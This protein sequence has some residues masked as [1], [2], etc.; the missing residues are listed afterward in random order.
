M[1]KD[2]SV[3]N[4]T[5]QGRAH[6]ER[7][8]LVCG[9]PNCGKSHLLRHMLEDKRLGGS[10]HTGNGSVPMRA[11]SRERCLAVRLSSPHESKFDPS[12]YHKSIDKKALAARRQNFR[13]INFAGAIQPGPR[14]LMPGIVEVCSGLIKSFEPE[15][16]RVVQLSPNQYGN[17]DYTLKTDEIDK[18]RRL[19]VEF[20]SIDARRGGGTVESANVRIL[21]DFFDFS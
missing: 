19:D 10:E 4:Q 1:T 16:I 2:F 17:T 3:V 12:E 20:I 14:N 13:R 5:K 6:F 21:A 18:L 9:G 7:M 15:R 11:L 8:L